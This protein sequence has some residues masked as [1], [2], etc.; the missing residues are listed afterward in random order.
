MSFN[1]SKTEYDRFCATPY[2]PHLR[3]G[4]AFFNHFGLHK[5]A[6]QREATAIYEKATKQEAWPLIERLIDYNQ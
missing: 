3:F 2:D 6:D 1:I 5:M 4:Q